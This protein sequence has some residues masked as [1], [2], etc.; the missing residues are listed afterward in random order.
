MLTPAFAGELFGA[1]QPLD[2]AKY[3]IVLPDAIGHG[4]S[5]KPSDGLRTQFPAYNYDDM[6]E[7][8][9]LLLADLGVTDLADPLPVVLLMAVVAGLLA[10]LSALWATLV[11]F[12]G[13]ALVVGGM[14]SLIP[15]RLFEAGVLQGVLSAIAAI[16]AS[17]VAGTSPPCRSI[18]A[19]VAS[20]KARNSR[21]TCCCSS[22]GPT[23]SCSP[24]RPPAGAT[25]CWPCR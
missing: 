19:R 23:R 11:T 8:Q 7:A 3:F 1:G 17:R 4:K 10:M 24:A 20:R 14:G 15:H 25:R 16:S 22:T 18:S 21:A 9:R 5:S 12:A 13:L 2:A 6:V